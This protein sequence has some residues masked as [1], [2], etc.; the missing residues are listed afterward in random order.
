M[1]SPSGPGARNPPNPSPTLEQPWR[2]RPPRSAPR[3]RSWASASSPMP[4]SRTCCWDGTAC[5]PA[6]HRVVSWRS[7]RRSFP[8][9]A[10]PSQHTPTSGASPWSTRPS[11]AA[12]RP[13]R[14][15]GS[16]SWPVVPRRPW[17]RADPSSRRSP[18]R[19]CTSV[20]WVPG[21]WRRGSTTCCW[22]C[23]WPRHWTPTN[24]PPSWAWTRPRS[25]EALAHGTGASAASG[26]VADAG[27]DTE[28]LRVNSAPYF[29]KDLEV[30]V[31]IAEAK[32]I[33]APESLVDLARGYFTR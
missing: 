26:I 15:A 33:R 9:R 31:G 2:P 7:T 20:R 18:T 29:M 32:G 19:S 12:G 25:R 27:F 14:K 28:Y 30:L 11:A 21:R 1:R 6:W 4:T 22:P 17:P 24:S 16:S 5:W 23:T 3:A 8:V 10:R 13:R